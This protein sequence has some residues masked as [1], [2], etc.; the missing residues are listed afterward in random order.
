MSLAS[1]LDYEQ[2]VC[3]GLLKDGIHIRHLA[4]EMHWHNGADGPLGLSL[5]QPSVCGGNVAFLLQILAQLGRV[6]VVRALVNIH[7]PW[8]CAGLRDSFCS[9]DEGVGNG[10]YD[11]AGLNARSDEG[12]PEGVGSI[13]HANAVLR[14]AKLGVSALKVGDHRSPDEAGTIESRSKYGN[15]VLFELLVRCYKI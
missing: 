9:S 12:K 13:G 6:H 8:E 15:E 4:I 3:L 1:I 2:P 10:D 5:T 7:K 11:V 14:T